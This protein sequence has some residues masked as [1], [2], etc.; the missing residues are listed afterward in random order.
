M[1]RIF[2]L[3]IALILLA[4]SAWAQTAYDLTSK[5]QIALEENNP[6][7]ALE[8]SKDLYEIS[9][10]NND[11]QSAGFSAY[12]TA[13]ILEKRSDPLAAA[14]A[15]DQ[16]RRHY[17]KINSPAQ[18]IQCQY[19]SALAFLVGHKKGKAIDALKSSAKNLEKINQD[20][21]ALASQVYLT[22]SNE[23]LPAKTDRSRGAQSKR[24]EVAEY[25]N[26]SL[27]AL[28]ATG[29]DESEN[30][31]SALFIKGLALEDAEKFD[32]AV[33]SYSKAIILY[34]VLPN[35]SDEALRNIQSR[36][37]IAKFGMEGGSE[38]DT[39]HVSLRNGENITLK[40]KRTKPVKYPKI[41]RN[42]MVDGARVRAKIQLSESGEVNHIEI[43]ESMPSKEFGDA[44]L[45]AVR[46]WEF[47]AP[48]GVKADEI[49]P[50]EYSMVFYVRRI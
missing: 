30:Y 36:L 32:E 42:Q 48:E 11:H 29:Q 49:P 35:H 47:S 4:G 7:L 10:D 3:L 41:N 1:P 26:R 20:K 12:V 13:G 6:D 34:Q 25:A 31:V 46:K 24:L 33:E 38:E 14:K 39:V 23:T 9:N 15:Y 21:S 8:I 40:I 19:K 17:D 43:L 44:F 16:C 22:L 5:L 28:R 45:K 50:F 2:A 27:L 37:S 18:A